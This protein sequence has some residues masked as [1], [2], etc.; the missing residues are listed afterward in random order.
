MRCYQ[1]RHF[2]FFN[3]DETTPSC[4]KQLLFHKIL[5]IQPPLNRGAILRH[6]VS[7]S[8]IPE[9]LRQPDLA[10]TLTRSLQQKP[11]DERESHSLASFRRS[12]RWTIGITGIF[13]VW[14]RL[15]RPAPTPDGIREGRLKL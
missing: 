8:G 12:R 13:L 4:A 1:A 5:E 11:A 9:R 10:I 3:H 6:Y 14:V 7:D 15:P 2:A